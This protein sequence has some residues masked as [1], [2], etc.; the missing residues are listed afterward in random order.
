MLRI[1]ICAV[2]LAMS[3]RAA[4]DDQ[5]DSYHQAIEQT[6]SDILN[7]VGQK[8]GSARAEKPAPVPTNADRVNADKLGE[9]AARFWS[10][11]QDELKE[12]IGRLQALRPA[13]TSLLRSEGVP[14]RLLAVVLVESAAR[15]FAL[16]PRN[17]RG[18]WQ[19]IPATARR[20]GLTVSTRSDDRV[21]AER[22]T[23]AAAR[24]LH[25]LY[26]QFGDWELALAA[27]NAGEDAVTRALSK[28]H[29][30]SFAELSLKRLLPQETRQ[31]VPAVMA[32]MDLLG[33]PAGEVA[34]PGSGRRLVYAST[35][36]G[37]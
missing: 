27:Y 25:D 22:A 16:S 35:R 24:Y 7:G 2:A 1:A 17:A 23:R 36:P 30:R 19:L 14:D 3:L 32:A 29:G 11:R 20:Y 31:Y 13:L 4:P 8:P 28:S 15:P 18:L 6:V 10:G 26:A 12:A 9:Y 21:Q 5:F 34:E 37:D 33:S